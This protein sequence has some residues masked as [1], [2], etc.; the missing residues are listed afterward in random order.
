MFFKKKRK[1]LSDK[2]DD[3]SIICA[4]CKFATRLHSSEDFM[5]SKKGLV[6]PNFSCRHYAFNHLISRPP[7]KRNLSTNKLSAKDFEI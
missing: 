2:I 5:C 4:T 6:P 1:V 3:V 7:R